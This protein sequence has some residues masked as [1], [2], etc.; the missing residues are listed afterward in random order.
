MPIPNPPAP[1]LDATTQPRRSQR[2]A[3]SASTNRPNTCLSGRASIAAMRLLSIPPWSVFLWP[4]TGP[5]MS[6]AIQGA[7]MSPIS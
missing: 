7:K 1:V 3:F 5:P 4:L 6:P 2:E